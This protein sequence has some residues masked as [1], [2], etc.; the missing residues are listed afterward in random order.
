MRTFNRLKLPKQFL[1]LLT[2]SLVVGAPAIVWACEGPGAMA[3]IERNQTLGW[4]LFGISG[5][6][7]GF[8]ALVCAL[9]SWPQS[10]P[11]VVLCAVHPGWWWGSGGDCGVMRVQA[12]YAATGVVLVFCASVLATRW[13]QTNVGAHS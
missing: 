7:T 3:T 11:L 10:W 9:K 5:L 13:R 2:I 1:F 8:T 6:L 12:S 4:V